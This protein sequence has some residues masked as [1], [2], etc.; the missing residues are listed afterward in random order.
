MK[1]A[2][3]LSSYEIITQKITFV[4]YL[5]NLET[6][7]KIR[8]R[9]NVSFYAQIPSETFLALTNSLRGTLKITSDTRLVY[10]KLASLLSDVNQ[11]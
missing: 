4:T 2:Q 8:C 3:Q 5:E 11:N 6:C 7:K 9:W 10:V 1:V